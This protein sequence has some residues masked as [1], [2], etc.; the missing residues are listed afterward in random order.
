MTRQDMYHAVS[1]GENERDQNKYQL[2]VI[3]CLTMFEPFPFLM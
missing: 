1:L 3:V 2:L